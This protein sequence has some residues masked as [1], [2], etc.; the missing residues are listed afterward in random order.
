MKAETL[1]CTLW[2]TRFG[3]VYGPVVR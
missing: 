2:R 1:G 3:G